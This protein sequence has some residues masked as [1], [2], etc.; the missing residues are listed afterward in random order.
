MPFNNTLIT[1]NTLNERLIHML[2]VRQSTQKFR[3]R[4][5]MQTSLVFFSETSLQI[6]AIQ[7]CKNYLVFESCPNMNLKYF[8]SLLS[9]RQD[10][11]GNVKYHCMHV[12]GEQVSVLSSYLHQMIVG[13]RM[14]FTFKKANS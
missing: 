1:L 14:Q 3:G 2:S 11:A 4:K 13:F 7:C 8:L 5:E 9:T 6:H 12:I 10:C